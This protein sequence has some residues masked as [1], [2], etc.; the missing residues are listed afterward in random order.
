VTVG[1]YSVD[2]MA[3]FRDRKA[4][5]RVYFRVLKGATRRTDVPTLCGD[6]KAGGVDRR[7]LL[8]RSMSA[9]AVPG[10]EADPR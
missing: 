10:D 5:D 6:T 4:G 7:G 2:V 1:G 8:N 9:A 3:R